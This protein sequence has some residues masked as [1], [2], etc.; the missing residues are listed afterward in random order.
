MRTPTVAVSWKAPEPKGRARPEASTGRALG[1]S[2][3]RLERALGLTSTPTIGPAGTLSEIQRRF[4]PTLEPTSRTERAGYRAR[5][6]RQKG[7]RASPALRLRS[8][9]AS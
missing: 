9:Y 8:V 4:A 2:R 6:S 3:R 5:R 7:R 1:T